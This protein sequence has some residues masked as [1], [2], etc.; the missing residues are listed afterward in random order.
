VPAGRPVAVHVGRIAREKNLGF[1]LEAVARARRE[2][3]DLLL[4]VAGEGPAKAELRRRAAALG[5]AD[6]VLWLGYLD[7]RTELAD[8]Y[9]G[10]DLFAFTSLTE[11]QGL[12]LLEAMS[13]GV[14]VVALA[15]RGTRDL[16]GAGRG[17]V[18]PPADPESFAVAM[19]GLLRDPERRAQL[20]AEARALAGEWSA[21]RFAG[22]LA[23]LYR[24]LALSA[25]STSPSPSPAAAARPRPRPAA[26]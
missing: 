26:P 22:Q 15:E 17:A 25:P 6:H 4:V 3:P 16:L 2:I 14:P 19:V 13:L 24:E 7:R 18:A 9:C 10:G 12:V 20:A 5:L 23:A 21:A 8:V 11:T 1:L